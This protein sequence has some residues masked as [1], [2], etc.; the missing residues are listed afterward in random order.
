MRDIASVYAAGTKRRLIIGCISTLVGIP[1]MVCRLALLA[2]VI[3]P[4]LDNLT[5]GG[6]GKT[7]PCL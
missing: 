2:I 1:A 3:F 4:A 6:G 7:P 5:A